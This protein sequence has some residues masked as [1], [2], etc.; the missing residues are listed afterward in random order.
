MASIDDNLGISNGSAVM[1]E[2]A[3]VLRL[4]AGDDASCQFLNEAEDSKVDSNLCTLTQAVGSANQV[5]L[6]K[7]TM[8]MKTSQPFFLP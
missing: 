8:A 3:T 5:L 2:A 1:L 7:D 4:T 6:E